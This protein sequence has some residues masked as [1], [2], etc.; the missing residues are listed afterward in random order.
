[1]RT[2]LHTIEKFEHAEVLCLTFY[3][4]VPAEVKSK[5]SF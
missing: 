2:G 4:Q 3:E 1:M 5:R